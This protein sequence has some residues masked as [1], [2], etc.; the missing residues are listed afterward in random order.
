MESSTRSPY[1]SSRRRAEH[2]YG[3]ES[4]MG[5]SW[6][7]PA[8]AG[9]RGLERGANARERA[10]DLSEGLYPDD[11]QRG[12]DPAS[13]TGTKGAYDPYTGAFGTAGTPVT[14]GYGMSGSTIGIGYTAGRRRWEEGGYR[15]AT[16]DAYA[17]EH[18][19][20]SAPAAAPRRSASKYEP[21]PAH[22]PSRTTRRGTSLLER[23]LGTADAGAGATG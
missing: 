6:A 13:L 18:G 5:G 2:A 19:G 7:L 17:Y 22:A 16:P 21:V 4:I 11:T 9:G 14:C 8:G 10:L 12:L 23:L 20:N 15:G 1:G 3:S